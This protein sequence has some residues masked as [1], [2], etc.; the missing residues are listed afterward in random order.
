MDPL[1]NNHNQTILELF[2]SD[3]MTWGQMYFKKHFSKPSPRFHYELITQASKNKYLAVASPRESAKS[4]YLSFLF[5]FHQIVFKKEPFIVLLSNTF[6]KAAM[7]LDAIKMEL[8][9]NVLL[10]QS[11]PGMGFMRDAEGDTI[12]SHADGFK[13]QFLCKGVDQIGSLRGVKFGPNRPGLVILDDVEDD[14]LVRSPERRVQLESEFDEVL[15]RLGHEGTRFIVVGTIL[16]DDS[17]LAKLVD[18]LKYEKYKKIIYRAHINPDTPEERSLWPEKWTIEN[19]RE[20]R[21][22]KP[23]VYAKEMQ[24]DPVAGTNVRF[25]QEYFRRWALEG[26]SAILMDSEGK[27]R[28]KYNLHDC[29]AAISCDLAWKER[30]ESDSSVILPGLLTTNNEILLMPYINEKGLRPDKLADLLF[31]FVERLQ[32]LTK[33]AVPIGFEK[34]MLENV[35]KWFLKREMKARNK[36]LQTRELV[37]DLDKNMRIETRL[38]PRYM[39]GVI[40]HQSG[41]GDIE[42]QLMRFPYGA[43]DDLIDAAQGLVQLLQFPK[44]QKSVPESEDS[45]K[46]WQRQASKLSSPTKKSFIGKFTS[47]GR[48]PFIKSTESWR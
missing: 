29:T 8:T 5:P 30:R 33:S 19:L 14:E 16:H 47:Q 2:E 22:T 24:N 28:V 15:G 25:K 45:F 17:Q 7:Y 23:N 40:Y 9:D 39:N 34:A 3:I 32:T 37:W 38:L 46:W 41:M 48:K 6:K 26:N 1:I 11:F 27:G 13:T 35:S 36:F 21:R 18:P 12:F 43:H 42:H 31:E 44:A 20:L 10:K 4:T